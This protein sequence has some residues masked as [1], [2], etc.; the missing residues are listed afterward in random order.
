VSPVL[1]IALALGLLG[2]AAGMFLLG[3]PANSAEAAQA[4][5]GPPWSSAEVTVEAVPGIATEVIPVDG[6]TYLRVDDSERWLA[7]PGSVAVGQRVRIQLLAEKGHYRS[8]QLGRTFDQLGFGYL[9]SPQGVD[10]NPGASLE[11]ASEPE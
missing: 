6:Y 7:V 3:V 4:S 1:R 8:R 10:E 5:G 9:S 11:G 2:T